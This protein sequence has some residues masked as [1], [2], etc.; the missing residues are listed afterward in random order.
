[1]HT[2]LNR[3]LEKNIISSEKASQ[4]TAYENQKPVSIFWE[5]RSLLYL[6]ISCLSG[7][8]GILIYQNIDSIGHSVLIGFIAIFCLVCFWYSCK[9]RTPFT[10]E[11]VQS[12]SFLSEYSLLGACV[13]FLVLE[14]YLQYQYNFFG[15]R[16]GLATFIPAVL[17]FGVAYFFDHRGILSMAI[18][19]A[20]S[21]LGLSIAPKSLF[22]TFDIITN[23]LVYT[24]I[25]FGV[26]LV[27]IGW[28]SEWKDKKKHFAFTYYFFGANV[29]FIS[30]LT[31]LFSFDWKFIHL[32]LLLA[33]S[34]VAIF[35]ARQTKSYL[36][37]L[38]VIIYGYIGFTYYVFSNFNFDQYLFFSFFYF[39]ISC[40]AV[41]YFLFNVKSILGISKSKNV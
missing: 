5:L 22:K 40:G 26:L 31:A 15:E 14:G 11:E 32:L 12:A 16:Y 27:L 19:A 6:G 20:G 34:A 4:I 2:L 1:M 24:G 37:L 25:A 13:L 18:T 7:G 35:H 36:L 8:L 21:W 30:I 29:A 39:M 28:L 23:D 3:L 33:M 9:H 38:M 10:W 41:V 17:F